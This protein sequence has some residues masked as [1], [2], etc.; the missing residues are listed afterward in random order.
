M[1]FFARPCHLRALRLGPGA[2]QR[3]QDSMDDTG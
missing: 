1:Q 2:E 3:V